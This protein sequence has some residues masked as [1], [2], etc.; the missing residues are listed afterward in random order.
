[1]SKLSSCYKRIKSRGIT[2]WIGITL[3]L[4]T[5]GLLPGLIPPQNPDKFLM[6]LAESSLRQEAN[7]KTPMKTAVD[8]RYQGFL[9][10]QW[11]AWTK[12]TFLLLICGI[13]SLLA[14]LNKRRGI[15]A[16]FGACALITLLYIY[17]ILPYILSGQYF[18]TASLLFSMFFRNE[19][20][21]SF[22]PV[23]HVSIAPVAYL[24][25]TLI[26]LFALLSKKYRH[27]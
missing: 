3:L 18:K 10:W 13:A 5:L 4:F 22:W 15:V 8:E 27:R 1:M 21:I 23:W 14:I 12:N 6:D 17:P 25:L 7:G 9:W 2:F 20:S 26:S 24:F 16:V 19:A 11:V